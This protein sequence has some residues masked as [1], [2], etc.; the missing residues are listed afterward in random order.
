MSF[1]GHALIAALAQSSAFEGWKLLG[2]VSE[3]ALL[4]S[5]AAFLLK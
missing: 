1:S 3:A 4:L 2:T 5:V